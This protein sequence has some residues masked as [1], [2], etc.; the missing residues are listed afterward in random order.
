VNTRIKT[1]KGCITAQI[2]ETDKEKQKSGSRKG[3]NKSE[4]AKKET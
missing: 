3:K 1:N 4:Q 2:S